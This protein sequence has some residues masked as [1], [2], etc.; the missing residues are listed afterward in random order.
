[1]AN[2]PYYI[3]TPIITK[4]LREGNGINKMVFMV[5]K[6]VA[7]RIVAAE[8][9]KEYG[10]LSIAVQAYSKANMEF[11]VSKESFVPVPGVDSSVISLDVYKENPYDIDDVEEFMKIVKASFSSRRKTLV[12]SLNS[13]LRGAISKDD[14][15]QILNTLELDERIRPEKISID[16]FTKL[17]NLANTHF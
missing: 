15:K 9:G 16:N 4:L 17:A 2:L 3:T 10:V 14:I 7:Q 1:M 8:G 11:L 6:E 5:Q 13:G 12:N